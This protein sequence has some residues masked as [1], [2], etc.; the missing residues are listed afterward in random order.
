MLLPDFVASRSGENVDNTDTRL[1]STCT[2]I[3]RH[4]VALT[5]P[6]V[7][8]LLHRYTCDCGPGLYL[9]PLLPGLHLFG[10]LSANPLAACSGGKTSNSRDSLNDG[11]HHGADAAD[12][13]QTIVN[14]HGDPLIRHAHPQVGAR[15]QCFSGKL[16]QSHYHVTPDAL[17]RRKIPATGVRGSPP[18]RNFY[19]R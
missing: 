9:S 17:S 7:R 18:L 12:G 5:L 6:G 13:L 4:Y 15:S 11:G 19:T 14:T 2:A 8:C 3:R 10:A 1:L 16:S